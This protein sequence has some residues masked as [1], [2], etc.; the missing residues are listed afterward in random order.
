MVGLQ[1]PLRGTSYLLVGPCSLE[2]L[3]RVD[4]DIWHGG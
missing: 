1:V 4:L 2:L 3:L